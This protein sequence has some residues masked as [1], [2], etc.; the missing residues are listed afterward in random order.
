MTNSLKYAFLGGGRGEVRVRLSQE[1]NGPARL[2]V[3]DTGVGLPAD[4]E[5]RRGGSLGL[6]LVGDLAKQLQGTLEVG[7]GPTFTITFVPRLHHVTAEIPPLP[8][9][10]SP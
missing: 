6:Q 8:E 5:T 1:S 2:S 10:G 9:S 7:P 3:S 4:F